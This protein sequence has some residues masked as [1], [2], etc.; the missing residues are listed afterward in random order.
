MVASHSSGQT[1]DLP[2]V[3]PRTCRI[4]P[5][6]LEDAYRAAAL[7]SERRE[8]TAGMA[9]ALA[10]IALYAYN[11][12]VASAT[13]SRFYFLLGLR[14][15]VVALGIWALRAAR[16]AETSRRFDWV[17]QVGVV[18]LAMSMVAVAFLRPST[19]FVP[20]MVNAMVVTAFYMAVPGPPRNQVPAAAVLTIG[21]GLLVAIRGFPSDPLSRLALPTALIFTNVIGLYYTRTVQTHRRRQS[22][23]YRV[24]RQTGDRLERALAEVKTLRGIIPICGHCKRVRED[25]GFWEQVEAFVAARSDA[26]FS[27][28]ICPECAARHY[29]GLDLSFDDPRPST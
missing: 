1:E 21:T 11:D 23:A 3:D 17:V 4:V 20:L 5:A 2:R 24:Q 9:V 8:I 10:A 28:G 22:L 15:V 7:P 25:D 13:S 27:H 26:A 18:G 14:L 16:R 6:D 12:W 19:S 29:P